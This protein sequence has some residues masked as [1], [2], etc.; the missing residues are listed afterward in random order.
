MKKN[1]NLDSLYQSFDSSEFKEDFENLKSEIQSITKWSK[2]NL[3]KVDLTNEQLIETMES[4]INLTNNFEKYIKL[5]TY[6]NLII[7]VDTLN[8]TAC[9]MSDT[10]AN[11]FAELS[12]PQVVFKSFLKNVDNL[13]EL[14]QKSDLLKEH[15]FFILE[16]K[17]FASHMLSEAEELIIAKMKITGSNSWKKFKEQLTSL[18]TVDIELKGEKKKLPITVIRNMADDGD[19]EVRKAAYFAELKAYENIDKSVA[20]A[21]NSIKGEVITTSKL[22]GY[23]SVLEMT[24]IESRLKRE[25]LNAMFA[26]IEKKMP[27]FTRYFQHK[28]KLLG[29]K[30]GLPFYDLFAPVGNAEMRF[31]YE[32]AT[33]FVEK[34]FADFNEELGTFARSAFD[35]E[36]V[37]VEPREG[38]EGGAFCHNIHEIKESRIMMNFTGSFGDVMTLAHELG[39]AYHGECLNDETYLNSD[40]TM[41]IA[42]TASTFCEGIVANACLKTVSKDEAI[43]ILEISISQMSQVVVDIYSRFLFEDTFIK[44]RESG[45]LSTEEISEIMLDAQRK[46]YGEGLDSNYLHKYMWL[47]KP[48]YYGYNYYNFPYAYG[49]LFAKGLYAKYLKVGNSFIDEYD[50]L[51]KATGRNSLEEIAKKAGIDVTSQEFWLT[52]LDIVEREIDKFIELSSKND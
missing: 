33:Q 41:P 11:I 34:N 37:D 14:I 6:T 31:T 45:T 22:R 1:W 49:A 52:S 15:E 51:L 23:N 7:S 39:H 42:E 28:A 19:A 18:L 36:W 46:A 20:Y 10:L 25:T 32:E 40:Y 21:L 17:Q 35:K 16:Q 9:K 27:I 48:H 38:K 13:E 4:Y 50:N 8:E 47:I 12:T 43:T 26:A 3:T 5:M 44:R 24:L 30:N 2:D 29:H